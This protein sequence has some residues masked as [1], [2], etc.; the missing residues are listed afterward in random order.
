MSVLT[1]LEKIK[2][3]RLKFPQG[4]VIVLYGK[5]SKRKRERE[6][7]REREVSKLK[8]AAKIRKKQ[9]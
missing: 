6:R 8:S 2:E 7:E 4:S 3:T 5:L 1:I 9:Y